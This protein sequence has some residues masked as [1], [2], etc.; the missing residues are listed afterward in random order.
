MDRSLSGSASD[1][2]PAAA[3][4]T[5]MA[6]A[7]A[8]GASG[9]VKAASITGHSRSSIP[10]PFSQAGDSSGSSGS[11]ATDLVGFGT[12]ASQRPS[13][14]QSVH[15][16]SG[17][18]LPLAVQRKQQQQ[19]EQHSGSE[20]PAAIAGAST[21]SSGSAPPPFHHLPSLTG[22]SSSALDEECAEGTCRGGTS[23]DDESAGKSAATLALEAEGHVTIAQQNLSQ[24][25]S[26]SSAYP[27]HNTASFFYRMRRELTE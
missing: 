23:A 22:T 26:T 8:P 25:D 12:L 2:P 14:D 4:G 13:L 18:H 3:A 27:F 10:S 11:G 24:L 5:S 21:F 16:T 15:F 6:A 1:G 20:S 17:D 7:A 9:P 19:Q